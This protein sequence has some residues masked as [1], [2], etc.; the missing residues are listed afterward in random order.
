VTVPLRIELARSGGYGGM[1]MYSSVDT[2]E[3]EPGDA[4]AVQAMVDDV[5]WA[6]LPAPAARAGAPDRFQYRVSVTG[7]DSHRE[8]LVGETEMPPAL[9]RLVDEVMVRG[10]AP[11]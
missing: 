8:V 10:R 2:D 6:S 3:L 7:A 9:R 11:S 5:D 1:T 4:E